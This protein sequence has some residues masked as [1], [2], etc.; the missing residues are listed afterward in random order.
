LRLAERN[1]RQL[2]LRM[3]RKWLARK[4]GNTL[5]DKSGKKKRR[6]QVHRYD[7]STWI[8]LPSKKMSDQPYLPTVKRRTKNA[9][10]H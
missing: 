7:P 8:K 9:Q 5:K 2:Q 1:S 10:R 4:E 6:S 3:A